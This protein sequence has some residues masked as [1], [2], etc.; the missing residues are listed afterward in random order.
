MI[1]WPCYKSYSADLGIG[2]SP[3]NYCEKEKKGLF[4][5]KFCALS[6]KFDIFSVSAQLK[7]E[8]KMVTHTYVINYKKLSPNIYSKKSIST[9]PISA[10]L[11]A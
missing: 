3:N 7:F 9:T 5:V 8:S 2:L 1:I 10:K 11:Y 4:Y 6:W